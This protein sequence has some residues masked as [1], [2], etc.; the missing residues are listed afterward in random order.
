MKSCHK[1][2]YVWLQRGSRG[3]IGFKVEELNR[4]IDEWNNHPCPL[5]DFWEWLSFEY[6][7]VLTGFDY[8]WNQGNPQMGYVHIIKKKVI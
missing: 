7:D 5:L 4:K 1:K 3:V 2:E 8:L 6:D